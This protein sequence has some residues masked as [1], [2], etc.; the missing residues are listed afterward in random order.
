MTTTTPFPK[1]LLQND[2][3]WYDGYVAEWDTEHLFTYFVPNDL[4]ASKY[5]RLVDDTVLSKFDK[6]EYLEDLEDEGV[7][8]DPEEYEYRLKEIP[9]REKH[10][11]IMFH[12]LRLRDPETNK[13]VDLLDSDAV[14]KWA[15][16]DLVDVITEV[17]Y[18]ES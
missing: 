1:A 15:G 5:Q 14:M 8:D 6:E 3:L 13:V 10:H 9:W 11:H 2:S 16:I 7:T 17:P 12:W 18:I 4:V